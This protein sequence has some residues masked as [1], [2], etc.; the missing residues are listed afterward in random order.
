MQ[1]MCSA[2]EGTLPESA[3]LTWSRFAHLKGEQW[4]LQCAPSL[5]AAHN[6]RASGGFDQ[7]RDA[8]FTS[9]IGTIQV[10]AVKQQCTPAQDHL[11]L[12]EASECFKLAWMKGYGMSRD[13]AQVQS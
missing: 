5:P 1:G 9:A 6:N 10:I 13:H 4:S 3:L 12:P 7:P 2:T 8:S 11:A